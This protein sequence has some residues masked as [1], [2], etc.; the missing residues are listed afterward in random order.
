VGDEPVG[1]GGVANGRTVASGELQ[2]A[3]TIRNRLAAFPTELTPVAP[4]VGMRFTKPFWAGISD[5]SITVAFRRW[6]APTVV[7][8]RPYRTGGGRVEV[9]SVEV[10]DPQAIKATDAR[11]AG[12]R[13]PDEV[14][15][16]LRGDPERSEQGWNVYRVEF[17][18]LDEPDPRAV[19][20]SDIAVSV[21][22]VA[23]I[24]A[25]LDR[26]DR[27]ASG[28]PWTR[29]TLELIAARPAVRAPDLAAS[30]GRDTPPF[31]LDVRKLKNLGLTVSLKVGY[32][33]SPRGQAY[34][35]ASTPIG[36]EVWNRGIGPVGSVGPSEPLG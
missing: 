2:D 32:Q 12:Y 20:A 3:G 4:E 1:S 36:A 11:R 35:N 29:Q 16:Q 10:V 27:A 28:G 33:L 31:K 19:L 34:L 7:T 26:L 14:R 23:A 13:S 24:D 9:I 8:G 15:A 6:R 17:Q 5:G 21:E 30:V 18:L 25:R 22:D